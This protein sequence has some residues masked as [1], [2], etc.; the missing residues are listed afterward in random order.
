M[1]FAAAV[2]ALVLAAAGPALAEPDNNA[3]LA[4]L[5]ESDSNLYFVMLDQPRETGNAPGLWIFAAHKA[6]PTVSGDR[7][8]G[9]WMHDQL[10]CSGRTLAHTLAYALKED[11]T[12][13]F[14][15]HT[16][17]P[18]RAVPESSV[19][20]AVLEYACGTEMNLGEAI[21]GVREAVRTAQ[22]QAN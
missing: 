8:V 20:E 9:A 19:D 1:K 16:G 22:S 15:D 5:E 7:I 3:R 21:A 12:E 14:R 18:P 10:D 4:L 6:P 13:A 11:F 17:T 2:A